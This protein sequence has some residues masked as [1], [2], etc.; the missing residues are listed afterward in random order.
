MNDLRRD[1]EN[2][3]MLCL[4]RA[5]EAGNAMPYLPGRPRLGPGPLSD[6]HSRSFAP[7]ERILACQ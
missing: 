7:E 3:S 2:R 6:L 1:S 5:K 4:F